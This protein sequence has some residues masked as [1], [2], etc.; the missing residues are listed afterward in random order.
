MT[1]RLTSHLHCILTVA[2]GGVAA[3]TAASHTVCDRRL[4]S[5]E[6]LSV[7]RI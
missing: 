1:V 7:A 3:V 2:L 5:H 6:A 4:C